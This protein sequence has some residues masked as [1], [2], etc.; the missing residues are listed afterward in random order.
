MAKP[1]KCRGSYFFGATLG[2]KMEL[3]FRSGTGQQQE[4]LRFPWYH[5]ARALVYG[6]HA[7]LTSPLLGIAGLTFRR[8]FYHHSGGRGGFFVVVFC[9]SFCHHY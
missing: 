4:L 3:A 9:S 6:V 5:F 8:R 7:F 2:L 1:A